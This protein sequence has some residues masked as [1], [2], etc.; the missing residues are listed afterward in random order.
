MKEIPL[1][2]G[3]SAFVDD[4]DYEWLSQWKWHATSTGYA[5]RCA[6]IN[7]KH[8]TLYMHQVILQTPIGFASDHIDKNRLNNQRSNLR[9]CSQRQN[10]FNRPK[11]KGARSQYKGVYL[12]EGRWKASAQADGKR[13][14]L[15]FFATEIDA[16]KAYDNVARRVH[17]EFANLNFPELTESQH[18]VSASAD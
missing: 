15:G 12:V 3:N 13:I 5:A 4:A 11:R 1:T 14:N 16:A 10:T 7:G 18:D 17:G 6:L 2:K 8:R 9:I